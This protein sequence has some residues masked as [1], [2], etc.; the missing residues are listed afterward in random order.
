MDVLL[1]ALGSVLLLLALID[2][3]WTTL[4]LE[5][6]GPI[7]G[8]F[9]GAHWNGYIWLRRRLD[10]HR[11]LAVAAPVILVG[12]VLMWAAMLWLGWVLIFSADPDSIIHGSTN[13]PANL[14]NRAYFVGYTLVTLGIGDYV[15]QGNWQLATVFCSLHGLFE[16][17]IGLSYLLPVLGAAT[18]GQQIA[19]T[20]AALGDTPTAVLTNAWTGDDFGTLGDHLMNIEGALALHSNAH[21]AYPVLHYFHS[22][23]PADAPPLRL[24][25]LERRSRSS[26]TPCVRRPTSRRRRGG[27]SVSPPRSTSASSSPSTS[28]PPTRPR[29]HPTSARSAR[30]GSPSTKPRCMRAWPNVTSVAACSS[31]SSSTTAGCGTTSLPT[32][33][34]AASKRSTRRSSCHQG[35]C[36]HSTVGG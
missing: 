32:P 19:S 36:A 21:K 28:S 29:R 17:T 13:E 3:L 8:R 18:E 27:P 30:L 24:A 12:V 7:A 34:R 4:A 26:S 2:A 33:R 25:I 35:G 11:V 15:P 16:L 31:A 23:N 14:L 10:S 22:T 9:A 1:F 20:I 6:A 5:Q